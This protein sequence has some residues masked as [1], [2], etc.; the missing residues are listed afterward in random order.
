MTWAWLAFKNWH[1]VGAQID[2][3][4]ENWDCASNS[5]IIHTHTTLYPVGLAAIYNTEIKYIKRNSFFD[6]Q[7]FT[8]RQR[9]PVCKTF[10]TWFLLLLLPNVF[11]H[12]A[13][14]KCNQPVC[15]A[16]RLIYPALFRYSMCYQ[17]KPV[18]TA[19]ERNS[20]LQ[21]NEHSPECR[22]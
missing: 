21:I 5:F 1:R 16:D 14:E 17:K 7:T 19:I 6:W 3:R 11:I 2:R 20:R 13:L 12:I 8:Q 10:C 18:S 9:R 22:K 4:K 15:L